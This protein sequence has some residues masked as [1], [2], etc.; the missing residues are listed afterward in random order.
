MKIDGVEVTVKNLP[1]VTGAEIMR[2]IEYVQDKVGKKPTSL[3][4]RGISDGNVTLYW[5]IDGVKFERI[6]R[7]TGVK[8]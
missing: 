5:N 6:R 1:D 8:R 7:I 4:I 3:E 2:Y